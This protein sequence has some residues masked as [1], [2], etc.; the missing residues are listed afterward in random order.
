MSMYVAAYDPDLRCYPNYSFEIGDV[1]CNVHAHGCKPTKLSYRDCHARQRARVGSRSFNERIAGDPRP[2]NESGPK[3]PE[4]GSYAF[5]NLLHGA[6][7]V[8]MTWS[9]ERLIPTAANRVRQ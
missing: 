2:K 3:N 5:E 6:L 8:L 7:A 1:G 9:G 4:K